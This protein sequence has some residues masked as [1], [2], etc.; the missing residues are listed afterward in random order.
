M[1]SNQIKK[2]RIKLKMTQAEI[3]NAL[4]LSERFWRYRESGTTPPPRWLVWALKGMLA[5][6]KK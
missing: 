1:N 3:C 4:E 6:H 5:K 2:A